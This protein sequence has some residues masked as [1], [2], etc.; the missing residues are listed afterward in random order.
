MMHV[1]RQPVADV[2]HRSEIGPLMKLLRLT[3]ARREVEVLA[4]DAAAEWAGD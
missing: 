2:D 3:D 1:R 4:A